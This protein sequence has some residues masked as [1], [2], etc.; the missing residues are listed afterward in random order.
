MG[1]KISVTPSVEFHKRMSG[2]SEKDIV[3]SGL[4]YSMERTARNV[5]REMS[6][7]G[8]CYK[9]FHFTDNGHCFGNESRS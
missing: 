1:G 8:S 4:D 2:A 5:S 6:S 9:S 3:H 7:R